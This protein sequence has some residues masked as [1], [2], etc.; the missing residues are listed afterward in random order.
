[1]A[2]KSVDRLVEVDGWSI[3]DLANRSGLDVERVEA[4][5]DGRWLPAP[6]ERLLLARA[7]DMDVDEIHWGHTLN[8]RNLRYHRFGLPKDFTSDE[9]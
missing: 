4:I 7:L 8:P 6:T 1:M 9:P 3:A 5:V 2:K